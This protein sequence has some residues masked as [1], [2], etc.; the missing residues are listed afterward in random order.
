[1]RIL[2]ATISMWLLGNYTLTGQNGLES[3]LNKYKV[4]TQL[5]FQFASTYTLDQSVYNSNEEMYEAVDNRLNFQLRRSRLILKAS[6][7]K[8][9]NFAMVTAMDFLGRDVLSAEQA[10]FNNG[11]RPGFSFWDLKMTY[12][13]Q[14]SSDLFHV[15]FG[16]FT[17]QFGRASITPALAATSF[18][19]PWSQNYVRRTL[20]GLGP[21]RAMGFN[22]GGQIWEEGRLLGLRYDIGLFSPIA[23]AYG[24]NS[25]GKRSSNLLTGKIGL[26]VGEPESKRYSPGHRINYYNKRRG[27]TLGIQG[28][29]QGNTDLYDSNNLYGVDMLFNY[30]HLNIDGEWIAF[31]RSG[32]DSGG[33]FT[34]KGNVKY[35][36]VS[37]NIGEDAVHMVEPVITYIKYN[38][39]MELAEQIQA[40]QVGAFAGKDTILELACRFHF[41]ESLRFTLAYTSNSGDTGETGPGAAFNNYLSQGGVGAIQRGDLIGVSMVIIL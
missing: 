20:V 8:N 9:F 21:G 30:D 11:D 16:Y 38:G 35:I 39:P 15:T 13:M 25:T 2:F 7:F 1:M 28:A 10:A 24:R 18:E 3:L 34:A 12:K 32:T 4:T 22:L 5:G 17:P 14:D 27:M 23:L 33:D 36:R 19:K 40:G 37:Y 29:H 31:R 26:S 6:P 41:S